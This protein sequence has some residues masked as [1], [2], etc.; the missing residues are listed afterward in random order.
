MN[1]VNTL[2]YEVK[3][4]P[5]HKRL[6]QIEL[7]NRAI[8]QFFKVIGDINIERLEY[9]PF[10]RYYLAEKLKEIVGESFL[11][12]IRQILHDRSSGGFTI[13]VQG[14]TDEAS[15][16]IRFAT[17]L[18]H[19]V[20]PPNHDAMSQKY[21]ARFS[22]KHSDDSDTYLRQAY[23]ILELH[24][25]GVFVEEPT[26]WLIMMKFEEIHAVGGESRLLHLDDWEDLQRFSRHPLASHQFKYSYADRGSKNV[27]DIVF[28]STFFEQNNAP[29]IRYNHQCTHPRNIEQAMYLKQI[30]ISMENSP[31]TL[32]VNLPVGELVMLNN[33]FWIHGREAFEEHPGLY[34]EL[35]RQRGAFAK[36]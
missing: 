18:T 36:M 34:R 33:H 10:E 9:V 15:D 26:D 7:N 19:L 20:G 23:R 1:E 2:A 4:H 24:T 22:V 13:G 30:Q 25:D 8:Q 35:M 14:Q 21:Y 17:A 28:D 31:G 3:V 32:P 5:D 6:R 12:T 29:C 16:Y 11:H 27:K